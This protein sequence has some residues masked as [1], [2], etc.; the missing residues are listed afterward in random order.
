[1]ATLCGP[2]KRLRPDPSR[3][4]VVEGT[5]RILQRPLQQTMFRSQSPSDRHSTQEPSL[6]IGV[7]SVQIE[8]A[9]PP[10]PQAR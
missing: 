9:L 1:M 4:K 2:E 10:L 5:Q 6:Q 8:Q 3:P 7:S